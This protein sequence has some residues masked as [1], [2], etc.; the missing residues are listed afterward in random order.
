[1]PG[2]TPAHVASVLADGLLVE[3]RLSGASTRLETAHDR[4]REVALVGLAPSVLAQLHTELGEALLRRCDRDHPGEQFFRIVDQL[5][6]GIMAVPDLH[7]DRRLELA[8]LN[9]EAGEL[10]LQTASHALA[11]GYFTRAREL[12]APWMAAARGGAGEHELCVAIMF[13][14]LRA[15]RDV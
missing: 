7:E 5:G 13:G 10:A 15:T 3:G 8:R 9:R 1:C 2:A 14:C 4:I 6:A 12:V 11:H